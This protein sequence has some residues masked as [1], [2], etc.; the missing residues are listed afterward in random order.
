MAIDYTKLLEEPKVRLELGRRCRTGNK[1]ETEEYLSN[2][3]DEN[4]TQMLS[5]EWDNRCSGV[6][7]ITEW[8]GFYFF[9]SS[10][11]EDEGPFSSLNEVLEDERFHIETSDNPLLKSTV[12]PSET[13]FEM[14]KEIA[15]QEGCTVAINGTNYVLVEGQLE[16]SVV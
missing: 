14:G 16:L 8:Q 7:Y 11:Y 13:L 4:E 6:N 1:E 5:L 10:D 3:I 12:V 2:L 15:G 9:K